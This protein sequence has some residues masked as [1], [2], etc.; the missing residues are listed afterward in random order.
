MLMRAEI[1]P[2]GLGQAEVVDSAMAEEAAV[3]D[4][5]DR[6][7]QNLWNIRVLHQPPLGA[8]LAFEQRGHQ[9]RLELVSAEV[10]RGTIYADLAHL[11][12]VEADVRGFAVVVR[13][14]PGRDHDA[15]AAELERPYLRL[16]A[17]AFFRI[18]RPSQHRPDLTSGSS[19]AD[20]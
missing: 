8:A 12:V 17:R 7:N 16:R 9:L 3:L 4:R 2:R 13:L 6:V 20:L 1:D 19:V 18:S 14:R 5:F 10:L 15:I 11:A